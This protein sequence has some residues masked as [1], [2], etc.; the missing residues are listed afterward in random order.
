MITK[1]NQTIRWRNWIPARQADEVQE[2]ALALKRKKDRRPR[3]RGPLYGESLGLALACYLVRR[4][5]ARP[6]R[7]HKYRGGMPAVRLNRVGDFMRQNYARDMRLMKLAELAGM[8]PHYFCELFKK[9]TGFSP[10]QYSI[11]CRIDRANIHLRSPHF[12]IRQVA[13]ATGFV[14][15]SHFTKVFG[16]SWALRRLSSAEREGSPKT[17]FNSGSYSQ[18]EFV[19]AA[20]SV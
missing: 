2:F 19:L 8:S 5:S 10:H 3:R 6:P 1:P 16:E 15:H 7:E 9:S 14:D 13:K 12:T 17:Y 11:R 4:Y 20:V 18:R